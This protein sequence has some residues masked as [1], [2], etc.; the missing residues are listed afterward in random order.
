MQLSDLVGIFPN[1]LS[2]SMCDRLLDCYDKAIAGGITHEGTIGKTAAVT[3]RNIKDSLDFDFYKARK[4]IPD[5]E[6]L[7]F[8]IR[9]TLNTHF[10]KYLQSL[11]RQDEYDSTKTLYNSGGFCWPILQIQRYKKGEGHYNAWH[12]EG[13]ILGNMPGAGERLFAFLTYLDDVEEGGETEFLYTNQKIKP[14]KG[15]MIIHPAGFPFVHKGN[16][17]VTSDKTILITWICQMPPPPVLH[18]HAM[19]QSTYLV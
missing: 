17:P 19:K 1:A 14:E 13:G 7:T 9:N 4:I 3:N 18:P 2:T 6:S 12:H 11:P 5:A 10:K 15:K 8:T 16:L